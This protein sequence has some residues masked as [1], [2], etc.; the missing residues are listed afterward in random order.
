MDA[1]LAE[2][3]LTDSNTEERSR[4]AVRQGEQRLCSV[5]PACFLRLK[6]TEQL[7]IEHGK[8]GISLFLLCFGCLFDGSRC[9]SV[10]L[11]INCVCVCDKPSLRLLLHGSPC[12]A[13]VSDDA[14]CS[15]SCLC[16]LWHLN[17]GK[18]CL[19]DDLNYAAV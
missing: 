9:G 19:C 17:E 18:L 1:N 3:V 16:D 7:F 4:S 12:S 13:A 14:L 15:H 10:Y 6:R 8:Q 2:G 11:C 5:V